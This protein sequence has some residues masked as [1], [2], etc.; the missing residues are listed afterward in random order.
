MVENQR[1][2]TDTE[3]RRK[4]IGVL[5]SGDHLFEG[6]V[7]TIELLKSKGGFLCR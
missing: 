5:W 7:E 6:T 1:R 2:S 3:E 4:N